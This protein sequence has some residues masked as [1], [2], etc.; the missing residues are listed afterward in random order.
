MHINFFFFYPPAGPHIKQTHAISDI[1]SLFL[2]S[3]NLAH[4]HVASILKNKN[5]TIHDMYIQS[6][7]T[8]QMYT[9]Y[10]FCLNI[11]ANKSIPAV[12]HVHKNK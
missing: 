9:D 1:F 8:V 10:A 5:K 4:A 12:S 11:M 7:C 6:E 3:R 2:Y